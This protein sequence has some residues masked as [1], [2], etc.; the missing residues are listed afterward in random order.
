MELLSLR[1]FQAVV[2]EGGVL[3]ASRKLNTVQ[4][5]ITTRI[6]KLEQEL[7]AELFYRKG[8]GLELAP[9]G[10]VLLEYSRQLL[11]LESR[12][13]AAVRQV[14]E[15]SGELRIGTMETFAAL[16]LPPALKT[17]RQTHPGLELRVETNTSSVLIERVF[18]HKLDCAFVGGLI[19]HPEL[20]AV[21]VLQEELVLVRSKQHADSQSALILFR[22]GCA[23]RDRALMWQREC[24]QQ[25]SEVMEL[26]T[27]DGILGCVAVG[28]GCTLV[29]RGII[30]QSRYQQDLSVESLPA[31]LSLIPTVLVQ[32]RHATPLKAVT[33]LITAV[34]SQKNNY[35]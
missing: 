16:R 18:N 9:S 32:H 34:A 4:S 33:S 5:N 3:S 31:H 6:K 12:A 27:L 13:G 22:E 15:H 8:R 29:P 35:S 30:N 2:D 28:L 11:Q 24:G 19:D 20:D 25:I 10:R 17:L 23:Y 14:G 1:T 26:G 7:G 21:E